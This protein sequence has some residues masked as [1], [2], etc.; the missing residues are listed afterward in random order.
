MKVLTIVTLFFLEVILPLAIA[1]AFVARL[2]FLERYMSLKKEHLKLLRKNDLPLF[3]ST[4]A[5]KS[6]ALRKFLHLKPLKE[7]VIS[8]VAIKNLALAAKYAERAVKK[9]PKNVNLLLLDAEIGHIRHEQRRFHHIMN[10]LCLPRF[11]PFSLKAKY[12]LLSAKNELFQTDMLSASEHA[13]KAL[14]A[15]Q[16]L[17]FEYE[18]AEA[19]L[20]IA[21]IYRIS[22]V[23]DVA[24]TMLREA[25][26]IYKK[27]NL[28]AKVAEVKAYFGLTEIGR[29]NYKPAAEYLENAEDICQKHKLFA[30]MADIKN[31]LG[32]IAFLTKKLKRAEQDFTAA[33]KNAKRTPTKTFATEMLARIYLKN[34]E[35]E[36]AL[37]LTDQAL[38]YAKADQHY[39]SIFESL[40]LKAEI[41]YFNQNYPACREILTALIKEKTPPSAIYYPA[42]AY[43]LL[44][45]V[46]FQENN[47][48]L[49]CTLFKQALDLEH[50]KNRLKGAAIDYNNLAELSRRQGLLPEAETYLKQALSYAEEIEDKELIKYLKSKL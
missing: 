49:A 40:Y 11:I 26:K 12:W 36:K 17:G 50:S 27:L 14:K 33:L 15:Y 28:Y 46:E 23:F 6:E 38:Q 21:Q 35:P 19:Y 37:Q 16:K 8:R 25:E 18:E 5:T 7:T 41:F 22:G 4:A 20:T 13:S 3:Y 9:D 39:P 10:L 45:L 29:E 32:L 42:N 34:K 47:L 2:R 44:G 43:T 1:F 24:F 30:T 31:W 48:N